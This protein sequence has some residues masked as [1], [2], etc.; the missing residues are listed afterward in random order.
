MTNK[1]AAWLSAIALMGMAVPALGQSVG[2][3]G[4]EAPDLTDSFQ[5]NPTGDFV[6][7]AGLT[8]PPSPFSA[9]AAPEGTQYALLQQGNGTLSSPGASYINRNLFDLTEGHQYT[10]TFAAAGRDG[11]GPNPIN[12]VVNGN[13]IG[14]GITPVNGTFG[15]FTTLPFT[16][17]NATPTDLFFVGV[18]AGGADITSFIDNVRIAVVPEPAAV[19]LLAMSGLGLLARRRRA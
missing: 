3:G 7:T 9:I 12:V 10:I 2:D 11:A 15:D 13:V 17:T 18:G 16:A 1:H 8:D 4:F 14:T 19:G 5:Y 6:G